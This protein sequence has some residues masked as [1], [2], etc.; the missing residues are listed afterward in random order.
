MTS[1]YATVTCTES[2]LVSHYA[3]TCTG[4]TSPTLN[5]LRWHPLYATCTEVTPPM[6]S[7]R[8]GGSTGGVCCFALFAHM[9]PNGEYWY[10][11]FGRR[12]TAI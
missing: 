4:V 3:N 9:K 7:D 12:Y 11:R 10:T 5:L 2:E 8:L 6:H 1:P